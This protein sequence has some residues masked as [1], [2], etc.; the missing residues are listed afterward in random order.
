MIKSI[1]LKERSEILGILATSIRRISGGL[2][3]FRHLEL[4]FM[5][6]GR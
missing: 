5:V 4:F 2:V 6:P 3:H 1:V